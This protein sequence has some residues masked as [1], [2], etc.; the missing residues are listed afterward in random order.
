[1]LCAKAPNGR[2]NGRVQGSTELRVAGGGSQSE[3][4]MQLTADVFGIPA[5]RPTCCTR[6]RAS[7]R[8]WTP[9][10]GIGIHPDFPTAI[11]EMTRVRDTFEPDMKVHERLR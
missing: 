11:R 3:A 1:M 8:Q 5:S 6:H 2:P 10:V 4:A 9:A 7:G